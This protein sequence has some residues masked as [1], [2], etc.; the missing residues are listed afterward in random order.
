MGELVILEQKNQVFKSCLS[1]TPRGKK[2]DLSTFYLRKIEAYCHVM[3][4]RRV[5]SRD[6]VPLRVLG[7]L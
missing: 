3:S 7:S 4:F 5:K 2:F 6:T 1:E